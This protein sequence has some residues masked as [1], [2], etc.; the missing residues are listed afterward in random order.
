M[1]TDTGYGKDI[2]RQKV[3]LTWVFRNLDD[4]LGPSYMVSGT[5]DNPP[6]EATLLSVYI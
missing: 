1:D 5:R 6:T 2:V 4:V 3:A